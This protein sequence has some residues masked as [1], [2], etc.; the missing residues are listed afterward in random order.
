[1]SERIVND[2]S[3]HGWVEEDGK[4]VWAGSG[5]SGGG[6]NGSGGGGGYWSQNYPH[7]YYN[8]GNVGVGTDD[9][10][11]EIHLFSSTPAMRMTTKDAGK[12]AF[13]GL[14]DNEFS[15]STTENINFKVGGY[16][17]LTIKSD[18]TSKFDDAVVIGPNSDLILKTAN[19]AGNTEARI[20][21]SNTVG[22]S[23]QAGA[24]APVS[25]IG[26]ASDRV[27]LGTPDSNFRAGY[28]E[29][30]NA[31]SVITSEIKASDYLNDTGT[32]IMRTMTEEEFE[33]ITPDEDTVY[34]LT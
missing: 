29:T 6:G 1:M 19:P 8:E 28:F 16:S 10:Q 12:D 11:D 14:Y 17:A 27:N 20:Y 24:I 22:I 2:P 23:F 13:M 26:E 33:N 31:D 25:N 7:V 30:V 34:F 32:P 4:W 21:H 5:G 9:P 3:Q 18:R 15:I